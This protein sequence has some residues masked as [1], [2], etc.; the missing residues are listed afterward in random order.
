M[1]ELDRGR[2]AYA[3]ADWALARECLRAAEAE[4]SLGAPDLV[5]AG[6]VALLLGDD[7][8]GADLLAR[9]HRS[10]LAGGDAEHAALCAFW[11]GMHLVNRGEL[12]PGYGWFARTHRLLA[13]EGGDWVVGGYLLLPAGWQA[14]AEGRLDEAADLF[15]RAAAEGERFREPDLLALAQAG[16]G[17]VLIAAGRPREGTALLDEAMVSVT[18]GELSPVTTGAVYCTLIDVCQRALDV[19]RAQEWTAA[20]EHW[21]SAQPGLVP[22]TGACLVHR[23]HITRLHGDWSL[24]LAEATHA[25][26]R[27]TAHD[28]RAAASGFVELGELH[29]L[30]GETDLADEAF[31]RAA[32]L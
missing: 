7:D 24:A 15:A 9:A 26:E 19:R 10:F 1:T 31:Q 11:L 20:L 16:H 28:P 27:L 29:S 21:W 14:V 17:H 32:A 4:A 3:A 13:S 6:Q 5:L 2:A 30:R 8:D 22:F 23:A 12:A 25:C 18:G